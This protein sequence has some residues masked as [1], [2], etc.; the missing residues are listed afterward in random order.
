MTKPDALDSVLHVAGMI[1]IRK[2]AYA[3][4][5][6][7]S[8]D[9]DLTVANLLYE[10][11]KDILVYALF[12]AIF[13]TAER[14]GSG[15]S[16][17]IAAP[18]PSAPAAI[19]LRDGTVSVKVAPGDI[20]SVVSA[21]N[22]VEFSLASGQK[23]LI[24]STLRAEEERLCPHGFVRIHRTRLVNAARIRRLAVRPSGDFDLE[25][26]NGEGLVGS[27]RYRPDVAG[28]VQPPPS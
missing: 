14:L 1:L 22:Y 10:L 15:P 16:A 27:R 13:W 8:Y 12:I 25:M 20:V 21:G 5:G 9:F 2:L 26:D 23:H 24:R 18:V 17:L 3:A 28:L 4:S 11:R 6:A 7:G 19:W